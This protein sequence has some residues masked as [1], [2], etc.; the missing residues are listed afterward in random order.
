MRKLLLI[1][2][3]IA[4]QPAFA[5]DAIKVL[6]TQ[7]ILRFIGLSPGEPDGAIGPKTRAA[8]AEYSEK[9][10][11]EETVDDVRSTMRRINISQRKPI[12]DQAWIATIRES[13]SV[14]MKDP[15]STQV[16]DLYLISSDRSAHICGQINGKNSYGAYAGFQ[17]MFANTLTAAPGEFGGYMFFIDSGES[18]FAERICTHV[19]E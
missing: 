6:E 4:A 13:A 16:R 1:A 18:D 17:W 8:I 2:A 14:D 12:S 11:S 3:F 5:A 15:S 19:H 7:V 9:Y 10:G